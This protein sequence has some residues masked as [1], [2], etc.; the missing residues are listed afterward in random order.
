MTTVIQ[1]AF[2]GGELTPSLYA[3]TDQS[4]YATGLRTMRNFFTM[5][6]GGA[7]NR[8]GTQYVCE[9]NDSSK[10]VKML[11]FVFNSEQT[12]V[13]EFGNLYMRVIRNGVPQYD[14]NVII[15]DI[16]QEAACMVTATAH[17]LSAGDEVYI[18]DVEGMTELNERNFKITNVNTDDFTLQEMDGL[19]DVDSRNF[20][21]YDSGGTAQRVYEIATPYVEAD[22]QEL[23]ISQSADVITIVHPTYSPR[24]LSRSGHTSWS[25]DEIT[26]APTMT[27]PTGCTGSVGVAGSGTTRYKITAVNAETF[28][29]SLGGLNT[30][31]KTITGITQADPGVVTATSHGFNNG[32]IVYIDGVVGMTELNGLEFEV[33]NKTAN[34]FEL[35]GVDTSAYTAWSSGGTVNQ[36]SVVLTSAAAPTA[37]NPNTLSWAIVDGAGEY[38]VYKELNGVYGFIGIAGSNSYSDDASVEPDTTETP[39]EPRKPFSGTDN[40]PA[41]TGIY[42]GRQ[43]YGNLNNDTERNFASRSGDRKNF[44]NRSP[45]QDDDPVTW[46]LPGRQVNQIRHYLDLGTLLVFTSNGEWEVQ[47]DASGVLKPGQ[48]NPVQRGY[49][50]SAKL[51]PIVIGNTALYVQARGSIIRDLAYEFASDGY[52]GND[53]T[54]FSAHLFDGYTIRDWAYQQIPHSIVWV[55]R[56]DGTLLGCTYIKEQQM[57]AWHRHDFQDGTVEQVVCVPEGANDALYVV[58]KRTIDGHTRRYIERFHQRL[59]SDIKDSVFMDSSLTYDGRNTNSSHTMTLSGGSDWDYEE[60]LTLTSSAAYFTA[61]DVGNEIHLTGSDG[62]LIRFTITGYTSTTVVT[63]TAH[64]DV[65]AAMQGVAISEWGKAVDEVSGLWHLEG[66]AVSVFADSFV[67]ANP[68]NSAYTAISVADG[69]ISL[70]KKYV[71]IHVGKP[72]TCDIETLDIDSLQT[73]PM[74]D[75]RKLV[76]KVF[77]YVEESRGLFAGTEAPAS[78]SSF[79][80]LNE[81]KLRN[82]EDY[83]S[84]AALL[85]EPIEITTQTTWTK[86]GHVFIRQ[87]DPVPATILAIAPAGFLPF[88]Q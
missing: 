34:T 6:H 33:A 42:Q 20:T 24:E 69:A 37:A 46:N 32:D 87:T 17:G 28:E 71:V 14:L 54:I 15:E 31:S 35:K 16:S 50:G 60:T 38:N 74:I 5:R 39:P 48:I 13:L 43:L 27:Q 11:P 30:T 25:L 45:L 83:D 3:R 52:Q 41:T 7:A 51:P 79:D 75:K 86:T 84:P 65:P 85:T 63:G 36:V 29:E 77:A 80:N 57:L 81:F 73:E 78:D 88:R 1:R 62:T 56:S 70:A 18:S 22:L 58:V 68:N 55:V 59:F 49:N 12:Y 19:T 82:D 40:F 61:A 76:N 67:V 4:K 44:S 8:P 64:K 72:Y 47:G 10:T 9:V 2:S 66:E 23:E 26:F 53:L 21:A